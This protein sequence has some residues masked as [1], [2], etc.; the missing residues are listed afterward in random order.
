MAYRACPL[1]DYR[2]KT[3]SDCGQA[4]ANAWED[5]C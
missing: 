3:E 4:Y 2:A 5:N 1:T